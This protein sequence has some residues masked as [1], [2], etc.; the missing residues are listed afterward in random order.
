MVSW[1]NCWGWRQVTG[2]VISQLATAFKETWA[3]EKAGRAP[4]ALALLFGEVP[5]FVGEDPPPRGEAGGDRGAGMGVVRRCGVADPR[6]AA[7]DLFLEVG[8]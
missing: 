7:A 5:D 2:K 1:E 8:D 4:P 3:L 6:C